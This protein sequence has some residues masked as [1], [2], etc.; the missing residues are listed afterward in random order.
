MKIRLLEIGPDLEIGTL[1]T[2]A[3]YLLADVVRASTELYSTVAAIRPWVCYLAEE[4]G[5][6]CG[7]CG[8]KGPPSNGKAEIAYFTFPGNE[9]RGIATEM[10]RSLVEIATRADDSVQVFAQTL[11]SRN[12]SHRVLEKLGFRPSVTIHHPDDGEVLEWLYSPV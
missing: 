1:S 12:A 8:F 11:P 9:S 5:S 4:D 10:G 3:P 7:T 6:I 2:D